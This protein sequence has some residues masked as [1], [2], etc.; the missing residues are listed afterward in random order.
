M[1]SLGD[2]SIARNKPR[3]RIE[4][5]CPTRALHQA[6]CIAR[7]KPRARI[8]THQNG[9][10][11]TILFVSPGINP[12]RGLKPIRCAMPTASSAVSPGINPGRGLKRQT[13]SATRSRPPRIARN[14]PRARIETAVAEL[15]RMGNGVVSP[16]I[17][18]GRGL[19]LPFHAVEPLKSWYRPE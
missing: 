13:R 17:N 19:K 18:P 6:R 2:G 8:E 11:N 15:Q 1:S 7:N 14:K 3:A 9:T 4:T 5:R 12:G 10:D 16:G